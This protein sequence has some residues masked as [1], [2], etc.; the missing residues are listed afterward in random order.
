MLHLKEKRC[1]FSD[2][3]NKLVLFNRNKVKLNIIISIMIEKK[4][5]LFKYLKSNKVRDMNYSKRLI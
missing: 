5:N 1:S 4:S 2:I 3:R